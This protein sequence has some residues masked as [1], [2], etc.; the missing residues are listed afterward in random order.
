[1]KSQSVEKLPAL[2]VIADETASAVVFTLR[3]S[4]GM[5]DEDFAR[6]TA[7]VSADLARLKRVLEDQPKEDSSDS[8]ET[9]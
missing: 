7:R 1:V 3:Q 9:N 5:S 4:T 8:S 2:R 6:W